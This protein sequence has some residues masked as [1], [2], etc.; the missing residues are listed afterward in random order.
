MKLLETIKENKVPKVLLKYIM[1]DFLDWSSIK[2]LILSVKEMNILED[3][4]KYIL[5]QAKNGIVWNCMTGQLAVAKWLYYVDNAD[6]HIDN[7]AAFS[8]ACTNGHLDVA[9]WLVK[10]S[11]PGCDIATNVF[12]SSADNNDTFRYCCKN[13]HLNVAQWLYSIGLINIHEGRDDPI[14]IY[15]NAFVQSCSN[16]MLHVAKWLAS[17]DN[18]KN[19]Q[20]QVAFE[21][22][23][24]SGQLDVAKWLYFNFIGN[25]ND[26]NSLVVGNKDL[27]TSVCCYG[28]LEVAQW[29]HSLGGINIDVE[30]DLIFI[31]SYKYFPY[32]IK[33]WLQNII[34]NIDQ[35]LIID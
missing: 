33:E 10:I 35:L 25:I 29:L 11:Q 18:I 4:H 20:Y 24:K 3:N 16:G 27:F 15:T 19:H 34:N 22:S 28:K 5:H 14:G 21:N 1:M 9:Q 32:K 23:C 8:L 12:I 7:N 31:F 17:V 13:G 30:N 26:N 6:I 2:K